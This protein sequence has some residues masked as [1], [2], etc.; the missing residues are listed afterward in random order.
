MNAPAKKKSQGCAKSVSLDDR[1][2]VEIQWLGEWWRL[3]SY[4]QKLFPEA[5]NHAV[6]LERDGDTARVVREKD[7]EVFP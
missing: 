7:G 5:Y 4:R 3:E 2:R 1:F 6:N